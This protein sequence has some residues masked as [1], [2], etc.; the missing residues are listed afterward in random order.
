M[1][2]YILLRTYLLAS[3]CP[4]TG[5]HSQPGE[6]NQESD[7]RTC[8]FNLQ[9]VFMDWAEVLERLFYNS[10]NPYCGMKYLFSAS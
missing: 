10:E 3:H 4:F 1:A 7:K 5:N 2:L 6:I 8:L 9:V